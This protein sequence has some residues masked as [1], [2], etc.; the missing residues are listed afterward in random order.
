MA[1]QSVKMDSIQVSKKVDISTSVTEIDDR[2]VAQ[3]TADLKND[4]IIYKMP[5]LETQFDCV[6]PAP[7]KRETFNCEYPTVDPNVKRVSRP[8]PFPEK[9]Q[10]LI[11]WTDAFVDRIA[12]MTAAQEKVQF[13]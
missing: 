3:H 2:V 4:T 11:G 1:T 7:Q 10:D 9:L 13:P 6:Y 5:V 8:L 12:S